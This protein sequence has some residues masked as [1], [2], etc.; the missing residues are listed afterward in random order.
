MR[1]SLRGTCR[2][3]AGRG[4]EE[5]AAGQTGA[6]GLTPPP[7]A[8]VGRDAPELRAPFSF[9]W[10]VGVSSTSCVLV[11]CLGVSDPSTRVLWSVILTVPGGPVDS[12]GLDQAHLGPELSGVFGSVRAPELSAPPPECGRWRPSWRMRGSG[13]GCGRSEEKLEMDLKD[14]E[15]HIDSANKNRD[16]AIK[17]LRLVGSWSDLA[18]GSIGPSTGW[19]LLGWPV[20]AGKCHVEGLGCGAV[21]KNLPAL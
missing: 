17:Q 21:V 2:A 13:D 3:V 7:W 4:E 18:L 19:T 1:P 15:A 14:L 6:E 12:L 9:H 20:S 8:E 5:K 10:S 11:L 16:E